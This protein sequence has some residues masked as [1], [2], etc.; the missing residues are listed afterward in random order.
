MFSQNR[1]KLALA[2]VAACGAVA[3]T[4]APA[5]KAEAH[6]L[7]VG[8]GIGAPGYYCGWGCAYP[9]A[10]GPYPYAY[11]PPG[12]VVVAPP[13]VAGAPVPTPG[14]LN[15]PPPPPGRPPNGS[16]WYFCSNPPGYY[17]QVPQCTMTWQQVQ[18][19]P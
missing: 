16:V 6:G 11:G 3:C 8:V 17:P 18:P 1:W 7:W 19:T 13:V 15:P 14:Y 4:L 12:A 9:Y 2:A 5:Q 10:Y